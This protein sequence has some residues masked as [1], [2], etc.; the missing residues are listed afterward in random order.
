M[1]HDCI[2]WSYGS[3]KMSEIKLMAWSGRPVIQYLTE[4]IVV[5]LYC[6][7]THYH[8]NHQAYNLNHNTRLSVNCDSNLTH[9]S[10]FCL[11]SQHQQNLRQGFWMSRQYFLTDFLYSMACLELQ[12]YEY[13][14]QMVRHRSPMN[15]WVKDTAHNIQQAACGIEIH[16]T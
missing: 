8:D 3:L 11:K 6:G 5:C 16:G 10:V 7:Y 12:Y 15:N 4:I 1:K 2:P 14:N 13:M 9:R